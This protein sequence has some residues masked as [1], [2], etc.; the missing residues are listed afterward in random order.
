MIRDAGRTR[1]EARRGP[2]IV[3]AGAV[4]STIVVDGREIASTELTEGELVADVEARLKLAVGQ[5]G[6]L[7]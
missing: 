3:P 1:G 6:G 5:K 2:G 4:R 7:R